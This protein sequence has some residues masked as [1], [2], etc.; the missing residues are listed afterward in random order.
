[1]MIAGVG[2]T[3]VRLLKEGYQALRKGAPGSLDF[4]LFTTTDLEAAPADK[5]S[6]F[7]YRVEV[8][9]TRRHHEVPAAHGVAAKTMLSLDL[10]Y[11]LTVWVNSAE[12]EHQI[13]QD[14]I[15]I[16]ERHAITSGP[17]LDPAYAWDPGDALKIVLDGD[18]HDDMMRV[19]K[20]LTPAYRLSVPY[21]VRTVKLAPVE[22][23]TATVSVHPFGRGVR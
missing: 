17:Q 11:L 3:L 19:W 21:L 2:T 5:V 6:L 16:L 23:T 8:D 7:L 18:A 10:R 1:M 12:R 15:E 9:P 14:C 4:Q 20:L 22:Q 13:L